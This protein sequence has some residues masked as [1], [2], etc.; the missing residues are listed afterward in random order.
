[1][2]RALSVF[3]FFFPIHLLF[4][5]IKNCLYNKGVLSPQKVGATVI[6]VGNISLGGTGKT[7]FT[8]ALSNFLANNG[9]SVGVVTRGY[10][11]KGRGNFLF[12]NHSLEDVG[13]EVMVL[14]NNLSGSIPIYVSKNKVLGSEKLV[15]LGCDTIVLDD[16]FQHRKIYRDIDVVLVGP[17]ELNKNKQKTFPWGALREPFYNINRADIIITNKTNLYDDTPT[18][19]NSLSLNIEFEEIVLSTAEPNTTINHL[20]KIKNVLSVSGIGKPENFHRSLSKLKIDVKKHIVYRDHH[21]FN[22][23]DVSNII[24]HI[25]KH[26]IEAIVCTE[27]DWVKLEFFKEKI[28]I[29]IYALKLKHVLNEKIQGAFLRLL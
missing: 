4:I 13:D 15:A 27:K 9:K 25:K 2:L 1:M 5:K 7:P 14:K 12:D 21:A 29:P 26:K 8:I 11:R 23:K 24:S 3:L 18:L 6:S 17:D 20:S 22:D 19:K 10:R 28:N 16:A